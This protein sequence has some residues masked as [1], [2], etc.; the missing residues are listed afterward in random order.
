M[1]RDQIGGRVD[2]EAVAQ[3][4]G[5]CGRP[6]YIG[7]G[8]KLFDASPCGRPAPAPQAPPGLDGIALAAADVEPTIK[9]PNQAWRQRH[10]P[11]NPGFTTLQR[12]DGGDAAIEIDR[13]RCKGENFGDPGAAEK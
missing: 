1:L 8:H 6:A 4:F 5:H 7:P 13:G 12:V 9:V 11:H 3:P 10:L 2:A